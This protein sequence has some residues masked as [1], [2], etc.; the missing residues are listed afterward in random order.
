V[1]VRGDWGDLGAMFKWL[2]EHPV[3]VEGPRGGRGSC[4]SG[5]GI[6]VPQRRRATG[7]R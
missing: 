6:L 2:E 3:I 4:S 1:F 7:A 5:G